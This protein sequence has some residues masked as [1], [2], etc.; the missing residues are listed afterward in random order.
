MLEDG[1]RLIDDVIHVGAGHVELFVRDHLFDKARIEIDEIARAAAD[2]GQV[3]DGETKPA[4]AGRAHHQPVMVARKM[5]VREL[6]GKLGVIDLVILPADPLLGHA[7]GAAGLEDVEGFAL[8]WRGHP[9]FRLEVAQRFV[10]KMRKLQH[11]GGCRYFLARVEVFFGPVQPEWAA[12]FGAEMPGEDLAQMGI[13]LVLG[14]FDG[15]GRDG[16]HAGLGG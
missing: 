6:F 2:M 13:E 8:E 16:C 12:G 3:L 5:R 4:R 7:G 9:D 15:F 14:F 11:V 10:R 1:D